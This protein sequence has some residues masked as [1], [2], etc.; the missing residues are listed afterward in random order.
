MYLQIIPLSILQTCTISLTGE[1]FWGFE[2][3]ITKYSI[4]YANDDEWAQRSKRLFPTLK[5]EDLKSFF[6]HFVQIA[7]VVCT[8]LITLYVQ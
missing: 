8:K 6:P 2:P 5:G 1:L 7:Q 3:L 4:Q